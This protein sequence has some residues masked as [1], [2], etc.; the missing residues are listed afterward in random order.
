M[1]GILLVK[2]IEEFIKNSDE[3]MTSNE[4]SYLM[5]SNLTEACA[6]K[7]S[8]EDLISYA[9]FNGTMQV[10]SIAIGMAVQH[11]LEWAKNIL[12][13]F[14]KTSSGM[15]FEKYNRDRVANWRMLGVQ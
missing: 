4:I 14:L 11:E 12:G 10:A 1:N 2:Q 7:K 6:D 9:I 5:L 8:I 15:E 13:K 3:R